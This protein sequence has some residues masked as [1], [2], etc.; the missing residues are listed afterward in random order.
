VS[1]RAMMPT[2]SDAK[3]VVE[4]GRDRVDRCILPCQRPF[5]DC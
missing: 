4:V 2:S 5:V 1:L 3:L